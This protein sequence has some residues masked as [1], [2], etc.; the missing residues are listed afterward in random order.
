MCTYHSVHYNNLLDQYN[1]VAFCS[2]AAGDDNATV[3]VTSSSGILIGSL[4]GLV[5][6]TITAC[7]VVIA[8]IFKR[9]SHSRLID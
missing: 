9:R 5:V 8:L 6:A 2:L 7:T 1:I 3:H 4:A